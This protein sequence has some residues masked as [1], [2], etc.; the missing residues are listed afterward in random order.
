MKR[1]S[2]CLVAAVLL[3]G[4]FAA[5]GMA[6]D[7]YKIGV[8]TGTVSQSEDEYRAAEM[9]RSKYGD[10]IKHVTYPDNF[11][12]EQETTIAQILGM[13]SDKD[14]KAIVICHAVP[15]AVAA[16]RKVREI[17]PDIIFVFG[18]PQEDPAI[19][20]VT[21]DLS[22]MPDDEA[23]GVTIPRL[24]KELGAKKFLFYSFPRHMSIELLAKQR[25]ATKAECA[26]LGM[27]FI[28][29]AAPDPMGEGGIPASQQFILEDVPRQVERHGKDVAFYSTNCAMQEPLINAVLDAGAIFPE[30]CCPSPTHGYPGAIG[31]EIT[32]AIQ[33]NMPGILREINRIIVSRGGAGRF[34][35]W[36]VPI[37]WLILESGVEIARDVIEGKIDLADMNA[38]KA[39]MS[40]IAG[41][42]VNMKK[43][44]EDKGNFYLVTC[45]SVVFG[46]DTF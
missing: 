10:M 36:P 11:M 37:M 15:G 1:L 19:V 13:A 5:E 3:I 6:K 40:S 34:A 7:V 26:K 20:N 9:L 41:V 22:F 38:V 17:R 2:L 30:Q 27:E 4:L 33:G 12:Q 32:D 21:A 8:M 16:A 39:K 43:Y 46:R 44:Y 25:D 29:V 14:V 31:L 42:D 35:T 45:G 28:F 24:A 23:R 18:A